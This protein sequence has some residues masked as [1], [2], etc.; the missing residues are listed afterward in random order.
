MCIRDRFIPYLQIG[1]T[2]ANLIPPYLV[3]IAWQVAPL[4]G[5]F[6]NPVSLG[7]Y[8]V[9]GQGHDGGRDFDWSLVL[10]M[11]QS[12]ANVG[13]AQLGGGDDMTHWNY[14]RREALLH[15]SSLLAGLPPGLEAPRCYGVAE[16][17]GDV[18]VSY[19]H[20]CV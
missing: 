4:G 11:V 9:S 13:M 8:R 10:K 17:P 2:T 19:T 18:T 7:L 3:E 1:A 5:G 16:R 20:L 6:G 12:P 14:W 15:A